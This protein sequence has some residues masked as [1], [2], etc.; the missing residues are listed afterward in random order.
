MKD[1]VSAEDLEKIKEQQRRKLEVETKQNRFW[2]DN[3]YDVFY[4]GTSPAEILNKQ[5]MTEDLTSEMIQNIAKK[6]INL[7]GFI[8]ATL[9]PDKNDE[10]PLK[11]F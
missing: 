1:G 10:K 5:K 6:Y 9:K 3:L 8:T 2:M 7:K 4:Y 11:G